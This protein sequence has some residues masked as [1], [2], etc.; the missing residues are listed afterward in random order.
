[1]A[2]LNSFCYG[3]FMDV[4]EIRK[5]CFIKLIAEYEGQ[6]P[7]AVKL[8]ISPGYVSQLKTG[9]R[10]INEKTADKFEKLLNKPKGWM[11]GLHQGGIK[12][13]SAQYSRKSI[14]RLAKLEEL[15]SIDPEAA[16][17]LEGI[18]DSLTQKG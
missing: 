12:E 13:V 14:D 7:L 8:E 17:R 9:R 3:V 18:I 2:L 6:Y 11:A 4:C 1:M 15:E 16:A 5:L 10:L